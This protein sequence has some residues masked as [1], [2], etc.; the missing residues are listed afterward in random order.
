[1]ISKLRSPRAL[2]REKKN[3][4]EIYEG[5]KIKTQETKKKHNREV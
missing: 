1:M 3:I 5:K 2:E 4:K